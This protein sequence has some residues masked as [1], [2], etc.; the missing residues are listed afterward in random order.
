MLTPA[1]LRPYQQRAISWLFEREAAVASLD[2]G[3]GK[4]IIALTAIVELIQTGAIRGT[5]VVAPKRVAELV[6]S[7]EASLW[8]H[9]AGL[10]VEVIAGTPKQRAAAVERA[11]NAHIIVVGI[12]NIEW[13]INN[14]AL[15]SCDLLVL[16][17]ISRLKSPKSKRA[18][19][20]AKIAPNF[21][22][23]WGLSGTIRPN[24]ALDLF[25]P[26][27][28][29]TRGQLW[30]SSFYAWRQRYFRPVDFQGYD[31]RPL[32]GAEEQIGMEFSKI[33]MR[34]D[35]GD[36]PG[37]PEL[38]TIIDQVDLPD[39]VAVEY[40]R[41][42]RRLL[43]EFDEGD[44][45]AITAAVASGK[46][47]Q[48]AQG[49]IYNDG[50]VVE[51]HGEKVDWL[52]DLVERLD[53]EPLLVCYTFIEDLRHIREA[54]P[55]VAILTGLEGAKAADLI[56]RWNAGQVP[57]LAIHPGSAGHGLNLQHGGHHIAWF[58]LPWSPELYDQTRKRIHRPG[59]KMPVVEH[60]C[61][62]RSTVDEMKRMRVLEK[63]SA[64]QAF[65]AYLETV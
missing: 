28:I 26:A 35:P 10:R 44:V 31:W 59:Q 18:K 53:G 65:A 8:E 32:P 61:L 36:M 64:Q 33:A 37:M 38:T 45:V 27:R 52:R 19:L 22:N 23:I 47:S 20:L 13:L 34:L 1:D 48:M 58:G 54:A 62:T 51:L 43:A 39:D 49:F 56:D 7:R 14:Y 55:L 6:W 3:A 30:G 21:P 25:M 24:S 41:M 12:D 50:Y 46:L 15:M 63:M 2:M 11:Q 17:E 29:I 4:T 57:V 42:E 16:D 60:I 9:T 5:L 40:K